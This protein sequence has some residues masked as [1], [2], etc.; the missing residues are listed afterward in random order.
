MARRKKR[1]LDHTLSKNSDKVTYQPLGLLAWCQTSS[2]VGA[3]ALNGEPPEK[4]HRAKPT[5]FLDENII[6][7]SKDDVRKIQTPLNDMV[8]FSMMVANYD[9][10]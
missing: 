1:L 8:V 10:K 4:R 6:F 5:S 2:N 9:E 7:F 3:E